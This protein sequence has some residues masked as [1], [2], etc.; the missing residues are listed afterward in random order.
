MQGD[1][2]G[3]DYVE[4][5]FMSCGFDMIVQE[6]GHRRLECIVTTFEDYTPHP[7]VEKYM[8]ELLQQYLDNVHDSEPVGPGQLEA[9]WAN[10]RHLKATLHSTLQISGVGNFVGYDKFSLHATSHYG[11]KGYHRPRY[12]VVEITIPRDA[13][14]NIANSKEL[15]RTSDDAALAKLLGIVSLSRGGQ[16]ACLLLINFLARSSKTSGQKRFNRLA[17]K[18]RGVSYGVAKRGWIALYP[19]ICLKRPAFSLADNSTDSGYTVFTLSFLSRFGWEDNVA[20]TE[21]DN[22]ISTEQRRRIEH[23]RRLQDCH[24]GDEISREDDYCDSAEGDSESAEDLEGE[25][26]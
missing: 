17:V 24:H 10:I 1:V 20:D 18:Y 13:G 11:K 2:Q 5:R 23:S 22:D 9:N 21:L 6:N 7:M 19:I 8:G 15:L 4:Y 26:T 25:I 14:G 3:R 12:D 16:K